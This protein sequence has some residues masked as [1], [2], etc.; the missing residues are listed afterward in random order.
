[1]IIKDKEHCKHKKKLFDMKDFDPAAAYTFLV[2]LFCIDA[3]NTDDW[4]NDTSDPSTGQWKCLNGI[5]NSREECM[6]DSPVSSK[7]YIYFHLTTDKVLT[8]LH[9]YLVLKDNIFLEPVFR[10]S[11]PAIQRFLHLIFFCCVFKHFRFPE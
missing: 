2:K 9:Y 7:K 11:C 8:L 6:H 1:M 3:T 4:S 5:E 10:R